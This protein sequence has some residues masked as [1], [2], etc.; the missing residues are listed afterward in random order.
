MHFSRGRTDERPGGDRVSQGLTQL[1]Q[2]QSSLRKGGLDFFKN[3]YFCNFYFYFYT[4]VLLSWVLTVPAAFG[5]SAAIFLILE[6]LL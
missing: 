6:A 5:L 4:G 1:C 2:L 3:Y